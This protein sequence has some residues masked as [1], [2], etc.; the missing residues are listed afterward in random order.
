M[1]G[2]TLDWLSEILTVLLFVAIVLLYFAIT[3]WPIPT[4]KV[5]ITTDSVDIINWMPVDRETKEIMMG[6]ETYEILIKT[7]MRRLKVCKCCN[8]VIE[9][10]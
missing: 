3:N 5:D 4:P 2:E 9:N 6:K 10:K 7:Y 1:I 8:Q